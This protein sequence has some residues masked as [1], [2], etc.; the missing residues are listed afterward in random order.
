MSV[1]EIVI[2]SNFAVTSIDDALWNASNKVLYLFLIIVAKFLFCNYSNFYFNL[3]N[4]CRNTWFPYRRMPLKME[5]W[6]SI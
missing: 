1:E 6:L 5:R 3:A 4:P 2:V